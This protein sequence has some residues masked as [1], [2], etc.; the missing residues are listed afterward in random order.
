MCIVLKRTEQ[1]RDTTEEPHVE[2]VGD[3]QNRD[4]LKPPVVSSSHWSTTY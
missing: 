1:H 4:N 2:I 3:Y